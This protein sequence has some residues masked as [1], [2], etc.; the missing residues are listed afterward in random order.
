MKIDLYPKFEEVFDDKQLEGIFYP[1]CKISDLAKGL[2]Q[3][4]FFVS[5]NGLWMDETNET[6]YN[7]F[8]F[9]IFD[10][11]EGKYAFKGDL[12][13]Y[14]GYTI[15]QKIFPI[16]Q[17]DFAR[18]GSTFLSDKMQPEQYIKYI[19][20]RL[21]VQSSDFDLD[22]YLE[23][24]YAYSI[25]QLN[26]EQTGNFGAY[27]AVIDGWSNLGESPQV[28]ETQNFG[29]IEVNSEYLLPHTVSLDQ[30]T[31]IGYIIGHEF[32]HDGNDCYLAY[33]PTHKNVL[34]INQYS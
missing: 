24:F 33:N 20:P 12:N 19:K 18:Q 26:Y 4:L 2:P 5:T 3:S 32:F 16:I 31:K 30:Y 28:Y 29:D 17:Q 7:G 23:T 22:Y 6:A 21:A 11:I 9:T 1:L 25:N 13:L 34:C 27:R 15:A 10:I 14:K 8:S